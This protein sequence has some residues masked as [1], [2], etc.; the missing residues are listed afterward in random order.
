MAI[1]PAAIAADPLGLVIF[2]I[3]ILVI[4]GGPNLCIESHRAQPGHPETHLQ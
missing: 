3:A 2:V 4:R 1:D